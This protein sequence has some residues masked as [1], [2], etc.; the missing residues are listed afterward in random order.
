M[1][2]LIIYSHPNVEGHCSRILKNV[3]KEL[4]EKKE[5]YEVLDLYK[6]K[7]DPV[8]HEK[9]LY[10]SGKKHQ[11]EDIKLIHSKIHEADK[12]IFIYPIWW[13]NYPAILRGF[14]DRVFVS[15]FAFRYEKKLGNMVPVGLIKG[16]KAT[17]FTTSG[18]SG[19]I[20][21]YIQG[22]RGDKVLK[23]D[24]LKFCGIKTKSFHYGK[25]LRINPETE[26][27]IEALV[28]KGMKWMY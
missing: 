28:K 3:E 5:K 13:N 23:N 14:I 20:F 26:K 4:K 11:S 27:K 7:F 9:E 18:G 8:L 21:K 16:K 10:S 17:I 15:G 2:T 22:S 6:I 19:L 1:K 25:A 24:T 12:L